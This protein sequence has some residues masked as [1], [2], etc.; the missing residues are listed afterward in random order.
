MAGTS[1]SWRRRPARSPGPSFFAGSQ[2]HPLRERENAAARVRAAGGGLTGPG[3]PTLGR[4]V[5]AHLWE[6]SLATHPRDLRVRCLQ[7]APPG[8]L[9]AMQR[10]RSDVPP[11]NW[12]IGPQMPRHE[13]TLAV[14]QETGIS[15][16]EAGEHVGGPLRCRGASPLSRPNGRDVVMLAC[17]SSRKRG[18]APG[19]IA[20][21][22][23]RH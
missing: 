14:R 3:A 19:A 9:Q 23:I 10:G 11:M 18:D 13:P 5:A 21:W 2:T 12:R 8:S 15:G 20:S 4:S 6:T 16:W 1:T 17:Q 7:W 22:T